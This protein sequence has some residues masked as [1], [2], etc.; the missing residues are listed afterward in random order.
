MVKVSQRF[1]QSLQDDLLASC[2]APGT[3]LYLWRDYSQDPHNKYLVL[4]CIKPFCLLFPINTDIPKFITRNHF[5][6]SVIELSTDNYPF[7]DHTSY[8]N[9][10]YVDDEFEFASLAGLVRSTSDCVKGK[11]NDQDLQKVISIVK[12][13][14]TIIGKHKTAILSWLTTT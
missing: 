7:L 8:L 6:S 5:E 11:L 4:A 12:S 14:E 1:P 10:H 2:L 13:S 9:C 3:I